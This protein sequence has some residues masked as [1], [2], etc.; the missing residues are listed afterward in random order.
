[1]NSLYFQYNILYLTNLLLIFV[2][3]EI[4]STNILITVL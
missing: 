4:I 1:M 2:A 3:L